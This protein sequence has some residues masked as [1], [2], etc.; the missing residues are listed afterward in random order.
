MVRPESRVTRMY[1]IREEFIPRG[2]PNRPGAPI[3]P[4][5]LIIHYTANDAPAAT[6][7][8]NVRYMARTY[9][10]GLYFAKDPKSGKVVAQ[11]GFIEAGSAGKGLRGGGI[12][13]RR[14]SAHVFCDRDSITRCIP[15]GEEAYGCGDRQLP[16]NNGCK[17]Q[18]A[19][20]KDFF[21]HRQNLLTV[22]LEICNN[23]DWGAAV[24]AAIQEAR[25]ILAVCAIPANRVYR[26]YDV[27]GKMCPRPFVDDPRA[28]EEFKRRLA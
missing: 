4:I 19:L 11:K 22:S 20:A 1:P 12:P 18:T 10:T 28:W 7:T 5:A 17:G 24:E 3:V 27:T 14:A 13:F 21:H 25:H 8:A 9:E 2:H 16:Y 15:Y 23:A 26:H 6:D